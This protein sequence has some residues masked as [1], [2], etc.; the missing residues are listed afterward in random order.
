MTS[1]SL[2]HIRKVLDK[3]ISWRG[4]PY[5]VLISISSALVFPI[6]WTL[7]TSLKPTT[8]IFRWPPTIFPQQ[9][10]LSHYIT[11]LARSPIPLNIMNSAIYSLA[12]TAFV[13]TIGTLTTYGFSMYKYKGSNKVALTFLATRILPPQALW[14]PF[15]IFFSK[16][17]LVN[18]RPAVIIYEIVLV[19]PLCVWML[20]GIFD[21]FPR[22][23]LDAA[24]IDGA[25]RLRTLTRI[26]VPLVAPGVGA[27]A[28]ISFLWTWNAFMFPFLI[29]HTPDVKP[30]TVGLFH[31]ISDRGIEWGPMSASGMLAMLPGL[32]F[33]IFAQRYIVEG[34]TQ[35]AID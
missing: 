8:E 20:K 30:I 2:N 34:L 33:F 3:L 12:A 28:I 27:I 25:S 17:G 23:L 21:A 22:D 10:T 31:F 15:I 19:Y 6:Y 4:T 26:V 11:A 29:L 16:M 35:G 13:V 14:L 24:R 32:I 1:T 5:I 7:A 18:S 9:F